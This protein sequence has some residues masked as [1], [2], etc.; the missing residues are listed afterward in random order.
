VAADLA[1][2]LAAM[3]CELA[4]NPAAPVG[5]Y[6]F[7]NAGETT[8]YGLADAILRCARR[9][10]AAVAALD[11]IASSEYPSLT[12]RPANSRL[13][14]GKLARDYGIVPRPWPEAVNAMLD[15]LL[16]A[17]RAA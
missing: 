9:H 14:T 3:G 1:A 12:S 13:S 10:G 15:E 8:W 2:A 7:V 16:A 6:H 11:P 4:R 17:G 5:I